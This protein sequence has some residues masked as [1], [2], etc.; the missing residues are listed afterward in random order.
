MNTTGESSTNFNVPVNVQSVSQVNSN[1][2]PFAKVDTYGIPNYSTTISSAQI[3]ELN[4]RSELPIDFTNGQTTAAVGQVV[5][6]GQNIGYKSGACSKGY[7]RPGPTCPTGTSHTRYFP[8][9]PQPAST[10]TAT[11]MGKIGFLVNGVSF[12]NWSDGPSYGNQR[13]WQNSAAGF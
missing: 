9:L 10:Q 2:Q 4:S 12:Y 5:I 13:V 1:G 6:F 8:L 11:G 7:W 3:Q